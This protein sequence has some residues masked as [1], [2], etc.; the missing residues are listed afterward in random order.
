MR[1]PAPCYEC[2]NHTPDCHG[3]CPH[4]SAWVRKRTA[5]RDELRKRRGYENDVVGFLSTKGM[6]EGWKTRQEKGRQK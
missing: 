5:E 4:Y 1:E 2:K 3:D 6:R